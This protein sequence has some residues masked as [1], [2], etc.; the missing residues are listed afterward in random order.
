MYFA[1]MYV[2][3]PCTCSTFGSQE[4]VLGLL[5]LELQA[6]MSHYLGTES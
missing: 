4:T 3:V 2:Y 5:E 1:Y 6:V